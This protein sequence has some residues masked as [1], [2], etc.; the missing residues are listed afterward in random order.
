MV[1]QSER[2]DFIERAMQGYFKEPTQEERDEFKKS[3]T[4]FDEV[5]FRL[6]QNNSRNEKQFMK[7]ATVGF[8][9]QNM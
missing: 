6:G 7:T 8:S 5:A 1:V 9:T 4:K 3:F 2:K